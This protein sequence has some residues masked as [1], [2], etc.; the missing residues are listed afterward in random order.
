MN[1]FTLG[2]DDVGY[3]ETIAGGAG[4][5]SSSVLCVCQLYPLCGYSVLSFKLYKVKRNITGIQYFIPFI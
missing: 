4:A 2:D 1:N 5:V 3:W